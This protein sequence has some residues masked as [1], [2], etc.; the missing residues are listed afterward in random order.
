[1]FFKCIRILFF[2]FRDLGNF[3]RKQVQLKFTLG[4]LSKQSDEKDCEKTYET[5]QRLVDDHYRKRYA[6]HDFSA[7]GLTAEQ[8]K[9]VL[10]DDFLRLLSESEKGFL[11]R[12]F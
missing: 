7:T 3:I 12:M 6:R 9:G 11:K 5:L 10:S 1:M 8:C 2:F 4:E